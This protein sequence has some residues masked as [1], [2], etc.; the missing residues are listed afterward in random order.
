MNLSKKKIKTTDPLETAREI[1]SN[2]H[3]PDIYFITW[4]QLHTSQFPVFIRVP[5]KN[6]I[7]KFSKF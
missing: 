4:N 7:E 2:A 6:V 1:Y 5:T 3:A